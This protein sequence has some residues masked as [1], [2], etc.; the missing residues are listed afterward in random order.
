MS[1][2]I[3]IL[4]IKNFRQYHDVKFDFNRHA[5]ISDIN[6]V[7]G[8]NRF[9]KTNILNSILWALYSEEIESNEGNTDIKNERYPQEDVLINLDIE[10][11]GEKENIK[12]NSSVGLSFIKKIRKT[13][14]YEP[15]ENPEIDIKNII[16]KSVSN[17]FLFRGEFLDTFFENRDENFLRDT[18]LNVSN[19]DKLTKIIDVLKLLEEKYMDEIAKKN[20]SDKKL[21][22]IITE[23]RELEAL[24]KKLHE[25]I[26][27][28]EFKI[29]SNYE[30]IEDV[31]NNLK[32][33]NQ[34]KI[35][36]LLGKESKLISSETNINAQIKKFKDNLHNIF[37]D[38]IS[39]WFLY[40][41]ITVFKKE[42]NEM[43]K[44]GLIPPPVN[45]QII[46]KILKEK[47]CICGCG[48]NPEMEKELKNLLDR[49]TK[50][51]TNLEG[52]YKL[53]LSLYA[54]KKQFDA[55]LSKV[56]GILEQKSI[57][58]T[59][60]IEIKKS[61]KN[62]SDELKN[63]N[64]QDITRLQIQ[65]ETAVED[66]EKLQGEI[67]DKNNSINTFETRKFVIDIDFKKHS[68]RVG[69]TELLNSKL[70]FSSDLRVKIEKIYKELFNKI[71]D[72]LNKKTKECF[73]Q[74]FWDNYKYINYEIKLTDNFDAEV[75]SPEGN[76]MINDLST[77][78]KKVLALSFMTALSDFYGFDFPLIID[79]PFTAL[80]KGVTMNVLDTLLTISKR[81]QVIIFTIPHETDIMNKLIENA[82]TVYK[83]NKDN[84]DNTIVEL[85]R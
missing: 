52:L 85:I 40:K 41:G 21:E 46:S 34:E 82:N 64:R 39:S 80:E 65:K 6:V 81:K 54:D 36:A 67:K 29:K 3:N 70:Q 71:H 31:N 32:N 22:K 2:R 14:K 60:L 48:L 4:E 8:G 16:P 78:E 47:K 63:I 19:L 56:R 35:N 15:S 53:S 43:E 30:K 24:I 37:R 57:L 12:R 28:N 51:K 69:G 68:S 33:L 5:T 42:L 66:I 76:N 10:N 1:R 17:L 45:Q 9:G 72:D 7:I 61:L 18:I 84:K 50:D 62:I 26:K 74:M 11:D 77:G 38:D 75:I 59:D 49:I 58:E 23:I 44:N 20:K 73:Q 79:A 13:G 55:L 83:L 27:I 25:D